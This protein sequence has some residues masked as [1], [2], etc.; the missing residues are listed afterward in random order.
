MERTVNEAL[1][2]AESTT[3]MMSCWKNAENHKL[4]LPGGTFYDV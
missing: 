3:L 2:D 4:S 1:S